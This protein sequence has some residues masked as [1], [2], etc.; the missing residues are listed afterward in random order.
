MWLITPLPLVRV[1]R[2]LSK[3]IRPRVG[4]SAVTVTPTVWCSMLVI[5]PKRLLRFSITVPRWS[6]GTS[7]QTCSNGSVRLPSI[8]LYK[9]VGRDTSIS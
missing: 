5:L 8:S 4:M 6:S 9:T 2:S 7:T 3:P 1:I